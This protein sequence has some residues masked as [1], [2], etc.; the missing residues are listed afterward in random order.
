MHMKDRTFNRES[1][2]KSKFWIGLNLGKNV[3]PARNATASPVTNLLQTRVPDQGQGLLIKCERRVLQLSGQPC[4]DCQLRTRFKAP[5]HPPHP[6]FLYAV[7]IV[8]HHCCE[9]P[10][11]PSSN[12]YWRGI[13]YSF[14][15]RPFD[16]LEF[17][18]SSQFPHTP[19]Y[20]GSYQASLST[21]SA[22]ARRATV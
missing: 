9:N 17:S 7:H 2:E 19:S 12:S 11:L 8:K 1:A 20:N 6:C 10:P 4:H 15:T 14:G 13:S 21:A 16:A 3:S 22:A 18:V 5:C